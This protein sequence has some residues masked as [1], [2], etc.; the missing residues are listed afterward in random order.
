[1][2]TGGSGGLFRFKCRGGLYSK[3]SRLALWFWF[4][5]V[6]PPSRSG[7]FVLWMLVEE[8]EEIFVIWSGVDKEW[9]VVI[10]VMGNDFSMCVDFFKGGAF[11]TRQQKS[12]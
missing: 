6:Q 4:F 5:P 9:W 8:P 10:F 7:F 11:S 2:K 12:S 3:P 1:M